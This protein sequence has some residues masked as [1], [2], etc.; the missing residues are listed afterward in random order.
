ME[1]EET[2]CDD[3]EAVMAF[4]YLGDRV[5]AGGECEAAVTARARYGW[6]KFG[7]SG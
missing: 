1:Q 5:S 6:V 4:T 2:L 7:E 3:V